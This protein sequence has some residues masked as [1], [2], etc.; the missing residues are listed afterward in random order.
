MKRLIF[1]FVGAAIAGLIFLALSREPETVSGNAYDS[2]RAAENADSPNAAVAD[3]KSARAAQ[4]DLDVDSEDDAPER[5]AEVVDEGSQS[6][7]ELGS[8]SEILN[9]IREIGPAVEQEVILTDRGMRY[10]M[11]GLLM[12]DV[13]YEEFLLA[14]GSDLVG[15]EQQDRLYELFYRMSLG[16]GA[17]IRF[18][19]IACGEKVC[20]ARL[21]GPDYETL[22]AFTNAVSDASEGQMLSRNFFDKTQSSG[23]VE[24]RLIFA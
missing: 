24:R 6:E 22:E 7:Q 4:E 1:V 18:D 8:E 3:E 11:T 2:A 5:L 19:T 17:S 15:L 14:L 12:D 13:H 10:E 21:Y 20:T 9:L 23:E 16:S